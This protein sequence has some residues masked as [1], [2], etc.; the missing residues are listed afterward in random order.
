MIGQKEAPRPANRGA[1]DE[2]KGGGSSSPMIHSP[3][4]PWKSDPGVHGL[5]L[6]I[7][8][9][10]TADLCEQIRLLEGIT[11]EAW[12]AAARRRILALA[13]VRRR[14]VVPR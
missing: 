8:A 11:D 7:V 3:A 2:T 4:Q 6:E 14:L 9:T 10:P 1:G 5:T 12:F 13:E